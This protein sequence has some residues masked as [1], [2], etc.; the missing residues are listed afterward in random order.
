MRK[1]S[2]VIIRAGILIDSVSEDAK[3]KKEIWITDGKITAIKEGH[4][5]DATIPNDA[6]VLNAEH[7]TVLPGIVD[8][9]VHITSGARPDYPKLRDEPVASA[10]I[11]GV[12]NVRDTLLGGITTIRSAG[13][14]DFIDV[15]LRDAIEAGTIPGPRLKAAGRGLCITGGH[16]WFHSI[17]CDG[18]DAFRQAARTLIK[19]GVDLIKIKVTGGVNTP[20]TR[21]GVPQMNLDE[22]KAVLTETR[23]RGIT[24][25]GH[26]EG[27]EGIRDA[28]EAGIDSIE[29]GYFI[30]DEESLVKMREKGIYLV[31]TLIAYDLIAISGDKGVPAEAVENAQ[32]TVKTN[33]D[34]FRMAVEFG[35]PIAMGSDAGTVFNDH[36]LSARELEYMVRCG[37]TPMQAI[38]A[39][40]SEGAK[41]LRLADKIGTIE[42]GKEADII[43]V[44]GNPLE[45]ISVITNVKTVVA[46]G[47]VV[48]KDGCAYV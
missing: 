21:P 20:G 36:G 10:A 47:K 41:L 16:G 14:R 45:D 23:K 38:K 42:V 43:A 13:T 32:M 39:G 24:L 6:Q 5:P 19:N 27:R 40:T 11:R 29:H 3:S 44:E 18:V 46:R 37:M 31:P 17:E 33:Q 30:D 22:I 25:I 1:V 48:K 12:S 4:T 7:L 26:T 28:V 8:A 2:D 9:H 15:N 34:S 35:V